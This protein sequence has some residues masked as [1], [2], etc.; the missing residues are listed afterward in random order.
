M[1]NCTQKM[2]GLNCPEKFFEIVN[3]LFEESAKMD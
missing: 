2:G 3:F 1:Y